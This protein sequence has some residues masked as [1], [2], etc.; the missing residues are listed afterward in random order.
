LASLQFSPVFAS[1]PL[2][3]W[4]GPSVLALL[5]SQYFVTG[6]PREPD[7]IKHHQV[8]FFNPRP[9]V[10]KLLKNYPIAPL[11]IGLES[12][13]YRRACRQAAE[14]LLNSQ[15]LAITTPRPGSPPFMQEI[16]F[17]IHF[18]PLAIRKATARGD[19]VR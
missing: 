11:A 7:G 18:S 8:L 6:F 14:M 5:T 9:S 2:H 15:F 4:Q 3:G 16:P 1:E 12:N 13:Q 17:P 19:H 10:L